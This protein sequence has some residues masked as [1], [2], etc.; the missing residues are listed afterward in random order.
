MGHMTM[1]DLSDTGSRSNVT[2]THSN[3]GALVLPYKTRHTGYAVYWVA[4]VG[5]RY[6]ALIV[7]SPNSL[8]LYCVDVGASGAWTLRFRL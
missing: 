5:I 6:I 3:T 7:S 8:P 2:G 1:S 4:T